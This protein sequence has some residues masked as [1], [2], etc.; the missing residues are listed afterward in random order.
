MTKGDRRAQRP[1]LTHVM[2]E[3]IVAPHAGLPVL[4]QLR[5]GHRRDPQAAGQVIHA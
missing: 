1:D 5:R 4:R 3:V 2:L